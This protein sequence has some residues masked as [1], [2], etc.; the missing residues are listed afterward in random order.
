MKSRILIADDHAMFR[1]GL[2]SLLSSNRS[3]EIARKVSDG[4]EV[5]KALETERFDVILLDINMPGMNGI[6]TVEIVRQKY[7]QVK[8]LMLSMFND[9]K[10]IQKVIKAGAHGYL[11]KDS[12]KKEL[13]EGITTVLEGGTFFVD[14]VKEVLIHGLRSENSFN[15]V[16]LTDREKDILELICREYTTQQIAQKLDVSTHT[17]ETYRKNLLAKT[18]AK[19][20]VGLLKFALENNLF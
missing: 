8:V 5:L 1:D 11:L 10:N 7:P 13:I 20:S 6:E 16:K 12:S 18:G 4:L 3:W 19:N 15:E 2:A 9:I 14:Q 17:V